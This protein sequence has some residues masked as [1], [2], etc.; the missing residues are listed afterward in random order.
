MQ[1]SYKGYYLEDD[2]LFGVIR[3][4]STVEDWRAK[5]P[6]YNA[7][8]EAEATKWIDDQVSVKGE[9]TE[10]DK[11]STGHNPIDFLQETIER[12]GFG[13]DKVDD[14]IPAL[15][16]ELQGNI[17]LTEKGIA[18]GAII[19]VGVHLPGFGYGRP[20]VASFYD[21]FKGIFPQ[22]DDATARM[23]TDVINA[24]GI[25]AMTDVARKS[26]ISGDRMTGSV[27]RVLD[28][29][30]AIIDD[31]LISMLDNVN[32]TFDD[33]TG[34]YAAVFS[35]L[36]MNDNITPA[37]MYPSINMYNKFV[38]RFMEAVRRDMTSQSEINEAED[39]IVELYKYTLSVLFMGGYV[40]KA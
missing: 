6:C 37:K 17:Y 1:N 22:A 34:V 24:R 25:R 39:F 40:R 28:A 16:D 2:T 7:H 36:I 3:V 4:Y 5:R 19:I 27:L 26:F 9:V 21:L 10:D 12:S 32:Y 18:A 11:Y 15:D 13:N 14:S 30:L 8:T 29:L 35:E 33:S 38:G 20:L 31:H 23:V